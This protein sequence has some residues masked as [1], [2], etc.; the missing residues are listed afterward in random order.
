MILHTWKSQNYKRRLTWLAFLITTLSW[1]HFLVCQDI[2][3][4]EGPRADKTHRATVADSIGM[5]TLVE[6]PT[7]SPNRQRFV[8]VVKRGNLEHNTNDYSL[9]LWTTHEIWHF[10]SPETI[11]VMSSSSNRPAIDNV[12][13]LANGNSLTFLGE[14]PGDVQQLYRSDLIHRTLEKLTS[15]PTSV[16]SYGIA[17]EENK[18]AY[19]A[20]AP[21][22]NVLDDRSRH[23]GILVTTQRLDLLLQGNL[24]QPGP[25]NERQLFVSDAKGIHRLNAGKIGGD[26]DC[27]ISPDGRYVVTEAEV[28]TI[29][30]D[31][32][33]YSDS[34]LKEYTQKALPPGEFSNLRKFVLVDTKTGM[35]QTLLN[36]PIRWVTSVAWSPDSRSVVLGGVYLPL[37]NTA[38]DEREKRRSSRFIVEVN[39]QT[40]AITKVADEDELS[41]HF[42]DRDYGEIA[43]TT[44]WDP[45][46]GTL[47]HLL[48]DWLKSTYLELKF[49]KN[50]AEWVKQPNVPL[51]D[52]APNI[53]LEQDINTPPKLVAEATGG[54]KVLLLDLN[55]QFGSL[56]FGKVEGIQWKGSDGHLVDGGLYYPVD[57]VKG[58]R[59]PLVIQT[60]GWNPSVFSIDGF[61]TTAFAAQA[62]AAKG[63]MVL[64]ADETMNGPDWDTFGETE[65]EVSTF[66]GAID[67]LDQRDLIDRNRVGLIG[68]SRTGVFVE[69]ALTRDKYKYAAAAVADGGGILTGISGFLLFG[70]V[71]REI[72]ISAEKTY[73]GLP[74]GPAVKTWL[75]LAPE[76]HLDKVTTPLRLLATDAGELMSEWPW[77]VSL[78]VLGKPIEMVYLP[79]G[80]HELQKP[81]NRMVSQQGDVDWFVFWLK[82]E[83]D[84][85]PA[86]AEQY[87]RWRELRRLQQQNE[88]SPSGPRVG[89]DTISV[90]PNL[91]ADTTG[92]PFIRGTE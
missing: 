43:R 35:S 44:T 52:R 12:R 81:W 73:G 38:G 46:T 66:E 82:G 13:W 53:F 78:Y 58:T 63:I 57:Y 21:I 64:Q 61:S 7:F 15:H 77:F 65:R 37:L 67:E 36:S 60:H 45:D 25:Y 22:E 19:I 30:D 6:G 80:I 51:S 31:W 92:T 47:I 62:L 48:H 17:S 74:F 54:L 49:R 89:L 11:A 50:G 39:V 33:E 68:F 55:P 23:N 2:R 29:P 88:Q 56:R 16:M 75:D 86:K 8:V 9:L 5:T 3:K 14:A 72:S 24:T 1:N 83:E 87:R 91:F 79:D 40:K 59:Y 20:E 69:T 70:N 42:N 71:S 32:K 28:E 10:P 90:S 4:E 84:P 26:P 41:E 18:V 76:S 85:D 27:V 34:Y